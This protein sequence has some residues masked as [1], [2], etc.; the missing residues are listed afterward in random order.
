MKDGYG[1]F[2]QVCLLILDGWGI[3]EKVTGNAVK[4]ARTPNMD[5][6]YRIYSYV[7]LKPSGEAVGLP[8]GQMGNS[9]VGHLNIG[10]G[11]VVY[12]EFTRINREIKNGNFYKNKILLNAIN[13]VR[14][15]DSSLHLLGLVSDGG[16]HSHINHLKALVELAETNGVKNLFIHA[17]LDGRDVPPR[18]AIPYLNEVDDYLKK[19]GIGHIATV[20]G[21]YYSMDRDNRWERTKKSYDAMVHREGSKFN[22]AAGVVESS[23]RD[24]V[25]DEFVIPAIVN[26]RDERRARINSGDSVIFFNFRPDR[27]RQLTRALISGGEFD[28]FD[29]GSRLPEVCF[30]C[31]TQY[32][33]EFNAPI[34]FPPAK[35]VNTLGEVISKNKLKQ[36]RIAETE[37]YA[38]VTF[39]FNGGIEKP[40]EGEDRILIPSP[41]VAT[42]DLKPEMSAYEITDTVIDE[43][44]LK[45]YNVIILNFANPDM[46][47]H[48]GDFKA[49]VKA[50]ETVDECAGRVVSELKRNEGIT[51][52]TADHGNAE[53]MLDTKTMKVITAHSKSPVPFIICDSKIKLKK[54]DGSFKL[55]DIAPTILD[56]LNIEKPVEMTGR[57]VI[58][59]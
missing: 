40:Y 18:S 34:A 43:I 39:F 4:M 2:K 16:V 57:S 15:K 55:S 12:Q 7:K 14:E 58:S 11:R 53:E 44:K 30:V 3:S 35:I 41:K 50:V 46:V 28:K 36:L 19:K 6:Y 33:K 49:A 24:N 38:H 17:F 22:T 27:A 42:Y 1:V 29:R 13:N 59:E 37:K 23:Y 10:A 54:D 32:D 8:E 48:T 21:R 25:D 56:V 9:E 47:G 52:I 51:I 31:M 26:C 5:S 20:S 45:K